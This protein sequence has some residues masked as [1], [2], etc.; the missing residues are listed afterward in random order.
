M[1]IAL[2]VMHIVVVACLLYFFKRVH[3]VALKH[4]LG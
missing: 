1:G 2:N 4:S 3:T